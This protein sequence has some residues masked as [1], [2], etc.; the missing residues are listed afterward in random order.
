MKEEQPVESARWYVVQSKPR[1]AQRAEIN[2][3]RQGYVV[4]HPRILL[5][6]VRRGKR[7]AVEDSLFTNYLFIRLRRWID[8]WSPLRS[9]F[10]VCRLV[11]FGNE[12]LAVP[13]TLMEGIRQRLA[14]A[15]VQPL[16]QP[17]QVLRVNAGVLNGL[18]AIFDAYDGEDRARLLIQMLGRPTEVVL[19]LSSL[20][21]SA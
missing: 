4:Y 12:P 15:P 20:A 11:S 16:Y 6:R 7:Q 17:G 2:L 9:T 21:R 5:E 13:D 1:Q 14:S 3:M 18:D 19:P 10:G 8:D